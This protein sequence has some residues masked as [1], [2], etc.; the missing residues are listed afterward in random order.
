MIPPGAESTKLYQAVGSM[1]RTVQDRGYGMI[2][3][4][5]RQRKIVTHETRPLWPQFL[6]RFWMTVPELISYQ[7]LSL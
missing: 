1:F 7:Q 2:K 3:P 6:A 5:M 4:T